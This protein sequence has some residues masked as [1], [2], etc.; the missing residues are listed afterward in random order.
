MVTF[1]SFLLLTGAST[2]YFLFAATFL[3]STGVAFY[4]DNLLL[5]TFGASAAAFKLTP[6]TFLAGE[7]SDEG[8]ILF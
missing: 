5:P 1:G 2:F 3:V 7:T 8:T 6:A 4:A